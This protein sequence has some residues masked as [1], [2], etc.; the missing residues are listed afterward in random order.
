[1]HA[2]IWRENSTE[3]MCPDQ[4]HTTNEMDST[5]AEKNYFIPFLHILISNYTSLQNEAV[6]FTSAD[7]FL[8]EFHCYFHY[9][10]RPTQWCMYTCTLSTGFFLLQRRKNK[11]FSSGS[12][13]VHVANCVYMLSLP[14]LQN[15]PKIMTKFVKST[16]SS[17]TKS[18]SKWFRYIVHTLIKEYVYEKVSAINVYN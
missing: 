15:W 8:L 2:G 17:I 6:P 14:P 13:L 5:C 16:H 4:V 3:S 10:Y 9:R 18:I 7:D 12:T 1:M 11:I